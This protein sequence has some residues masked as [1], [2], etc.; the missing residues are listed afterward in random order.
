MSMDDGRTTQ[1]I[2]VGSQVPAWRAKAFLPNGD[3][4]DLDS[5]ALAGK[6]TVLFFWPLDFTFVCPTE[7]VAFA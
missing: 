4:M 3:F 7:I 6:W 1:G 5:Q 2:Q